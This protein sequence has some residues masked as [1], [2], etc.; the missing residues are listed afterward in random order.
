MSIRFPK[1]GSGQFYFFRVDGSG[2]VVGDATTP[3]QTDTTFIVEFNE[4]RT[5]LGWRPSQVDCQLCATV[6]G[7]VSDARTGNPIAGARVTATGQLDV[8]GQ[9]VPFT[10]SATT[11]AD[12]RYTLSDALGRT[13]VPQGPVNLSVT[14]D[15]HEPQTIAVAVPGD[16]NV[17]V[18]ITLVCTV[19]SGRVVDEHGLPVTDAVVVLTE[20]DG[21]AVGKLVN[22]DGTFTFEC[23]KHGTVTVWT[24]GAAQL[25]RTVPAMGG[26]SGLILTVISTCADIVG[27]VTD[28]DPPHVPIVNAESESCR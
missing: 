14:D 27:K 8:Q 24:D 4:V 1:G 12:G 11:A 13:C 23:V 22:P 5:G 17:T 18:P 15:R 7:T 25:T 19:V 9:M 28:A 3:F 10:Y 16:G 6:T 2:G 26:L 21:Q 20:S